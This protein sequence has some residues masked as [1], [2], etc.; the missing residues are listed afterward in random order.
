M[1]RLL[2]SDKKGFV[3]AAAFWLWGTLRRWALIPDRRELRAIGRTVSGRSLLELGC[4]D[5]RFMELARSCGWRTTGSEV[6]PRH[7]AY[8]RERLGLDVVTCGGEALPKP[9]EPYDLI[10]CRYVLEHVEN[11]HRLLVAMHDLLAPR[12]KILCMVPN[13]QSLQARVFGNRWLQ[14][15]I[16]G[17][18]H[19]FDIETMHA[20]LSECGFT[21]I[22]IDTPF[23]AIEPYGWAVSLFP[24]LDPER[25]GGWPFVKTT[26]LV[27]MS[28]CT[29][30]L[31]FFAIWF[32]GGA[33]LRAVAGKRV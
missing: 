30:P 7:A 24:A 4:G 15:R 28:L 11:P 2:S 27:I 16:S 21:G 6:D 1:S 32:D 31:S 10:V 8:C 12:G 19:F 13:A 14:R 25:H 18:R 29:L 3:Q 33:T 9:N 17:H 5:G 20:L 23:S 22:V 26:I